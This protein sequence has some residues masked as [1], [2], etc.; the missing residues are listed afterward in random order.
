MLECN[1]RRATKMIQGIEHLS[2]LREL[3]LF[4]LEREGSRRPDSGLSISKVELQGRTD[5][6]AG[7]L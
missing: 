5:S 1:D 7:P 2:W 6:L 3:R 4:S